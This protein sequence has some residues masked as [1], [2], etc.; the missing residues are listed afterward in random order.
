[1]TRNIQKYDLNFSI[2]LLVA[3]HIF[4][5]IPRGRSSYRRCS[6]RKRVLTN[7]V[8]FTGKRLNPPTILKKKLWYRCFPV[9]FAKFLR[10]PFLQNISGWLLLKGCFWMLA[11]LTLARLDFFKVVFSEGRIFQ[12]LNNLFKVQYSLQLMDTLKGGHLW[13]ADKFFFHRPNSG[14]S[15]VKNFLKGRQVISGHSN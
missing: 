1:M 6:L 15:F 5:K 14:E 2:L 7:F 4:G 12:L 11:I 9:I 3:F 13:I 10:A 8:K